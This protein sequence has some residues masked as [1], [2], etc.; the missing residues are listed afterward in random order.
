VRALAVA[1]I[2]LSMTISSAPL[3][4]A[5][6]ARVAPRGTPGVERDA[7]GVPHITAPDDREAMRLLGYVHAQD[8]L[9]QMDSLRRQLSGTLAELVGTDAIAS[10]IQF[11]TLGLRR[12]AEASFDAYS[13]ETRELAESY[14]AGVN[15]AIADMAE[16]PPEYAALELTKAGIPAWTALDSLTVGKGIAF[17]QSF[18]TTDLELTVALA[19]YQEA[20]EAGGF[21]GTALFFEDAFR[22]A[23]FD[24]TLTVPGFLD[25]P[26]R[27]PASPATLEAARNLRRAI[28][29]ETV[30]LARQY[31]DT[32]RSV[33][34][35]AALAHRGESVSGSNWWLVSGSRTTTG[36]P[37]LA[38]DPHLSL[39]MAPVFYEVHIRVTND[40][41]RGPM[42]VA[43]VSFAGA[44]A[45][46]LGTNERIAWALTYN[47]LDVTD[48]YQE[49]ITFNFRTARLKSTT[50][51]NKKEKLV[52]IAQEYRA[53]LVGNGTVDDGAFVEVLPN[54]GG[55]T[56]VVPRR[57]NGPI[58]SV[59]SSG[60]LDD[61]AGISVQYT[62]WGPTRDLEAFLA[63]ARAETVDE[64]AAGV[65]LL[66]MPTL[67]AG[68]ATADGHIA[69]F[70][71]GELP[72]RED[73]EKLGR[74]DG[75][76]PFLV[77]DGTHA[78][79]NEWIRQK[80]RPADQAIPYRILPFDEMPNVRDPE[81]G[82]IANGN[83]DPVG[84]TLDG[85]PLD[86]RRPTGGI[87]YLN[88]GYEGGFRVGRI[89]RL[90]DAALEGGGRV[91]L[92][93]MA[94]I[95]SNNQMLDAEA[96]VPFVVDAFEAAA[97]PG[98][99]P[100]LAALGSDPRVAEAVARLSSWQFGAP[101]GLREGYDPGDDPENL[102]EPSESEVRASV[103]ATIYSVWRSRVMA[104]TIDATLARVGLG[105]AVPIDSA[106]MAALR[107]LLDTF[108]TARGVGASGLS[109]FEVDGAPTPEAARDIVL[110]RSLAEALDALAGDD[111]AA[112][113]G[114]ST[115]QLDYRWG[116]LHRIVFAHPL[117]APFDVP[118]AGGF[119]DLAPG[120]PG[121]PKAGGYGVVD[122]S[123]HDVR[124]SSSN[125]FMFN[126]GPA[127][128][129]VGQVTPAGPEAFQIIPGG[130]SG[131]VRSPHYASQLGRWL[132]NRFH[133]LSIE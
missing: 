119:A 124:A 37:M 48:F 81:A 34:A 58:I 106:A 5:P 57:N 12:A 4:A 121:V 114:R 88:V 72:L 118:S 45:I 78:F 87:Y 82:Y 27:G 95:Q 103:A 59:D 71:S 98:A 56:Y 113:F 53:N 94:R 63:F 43:G 126:H 65:R 62:G 11:R 46:I 131:D 70:T 77:R 108:P 2:A 66:D 110:L 40:P 116:R 54:A 64:F 73:L 15:A 115:D 18:D 10:D 22:G 76:P 125:D 99:A 130:Q 104:N 47:P 26:A 67:N 79:R 21:D 75:V 117:G 30:R 127:R 68:V 14:A 112:A 7:E 60:G 120:L 16:L 128:R 36:N 19:A 89:A 84:T 123:S 32:I 35:L 55:V 111:F 101:T 83:N 13:R 6:P 109:F 107:H 74:V 33:P 29:P 52:L 38:S 122:A 102:P 69:Y 42:N 133:P 85:D 28:R 90:L 97:E 3:G 39:P 51:G 105:G 93:D 31:L 132:T 23:P 96:L 1:L 86:E 17:G 91:S 129:F 20:G 49:K 80:R 50:Y 24:P 41:A 9:F 61:L 44:P 8:R 100:E 92:D 25:R